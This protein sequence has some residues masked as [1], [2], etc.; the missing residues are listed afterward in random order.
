MRPCSTIPG[1]PPCVRICSEDTGYL[2]G[3]E[4]LPIKQRPP[5]TKVGIHINGTAFRAPD[6]MN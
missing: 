5:P 4:E 6:A 3:S 1:G 2:L